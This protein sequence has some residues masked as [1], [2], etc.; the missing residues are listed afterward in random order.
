MAVSM[1]L[2]RLARVLEIEEEQ[3][4]LALEAALSNLRSLERALLAT[5]ERERKGRQL[6]VA[7]AGT[8]ELPDRL[9][10]IE[11]TR[12]SARRAEALSPRIK[13]AELNAAALQQVF[14]AKRVERRQAETLLE[15]AQA[16]DALQASRRSQRGLDDWY[17]SQ[18]RGP[19][20][21]KEPNRQGVFGDA[22]RDPAE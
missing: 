16:R 12:C 19:D 17:L 10:G 20:G 22:V 21:T 18:L 5:T 2:R 7:S 9:A 6:I 3:C 11:E 13:E 8:G 1:A 15:E 4:R 14:L